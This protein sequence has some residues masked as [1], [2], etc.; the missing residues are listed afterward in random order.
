ME[1]IYLKAE[2]HVEVSSLNL[3]IKDVCQVYTKNRVL[4]NK[5][6]SM[7]LCNLQ[8]ED[9]EKTIF[10]MMAVIRGIEKF[11]GQ[12]NVLLV[13]LGESDV[14]VHY[15]KGKKANKMMELLKVAGV[16]LVTFFGAAFAIMAYNEDV[17]VSS[18]FSKIYQIF[19]G[20]EPQGPTILELTYSIGIA[21]GVI[22]FF[23]HFGKIKFTK[24][25]TPMEVEM[26]K[27]EEDVCDT[28]IKVKSRKGESVD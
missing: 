25:P 27:Y 23:N 11:L 26:E 1:T 13:N 20:V 6:Q 12:E 5:V 10:S 4:Q 17:N 18:V 14:I 22:I 28:I 3:K 16:A 24:D 7:T 19:L 8:S 2:K 21:F 15:V 9:G